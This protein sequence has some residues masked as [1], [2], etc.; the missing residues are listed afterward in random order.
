MASPEFVQRPPETP[1]IQKPTPMAIFL[2]VSVRLKSPEP[3][4]PRGARGVTMDFGILGVFCRRYAVRHTGG[5]RDGLRSVADCAPE[6][7]RRAPGHHTAPEDGFRLTPGGSP[8]PRGAGALWR[9]PAHFRC[10]GRRV[11]PSGAFLRCSSGC[12]HSRDFRSALSVRR[13][14]NGLDLRVLEHVFP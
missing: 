12:R 14:E 2:F 5:G 13:A 1:R 8:H 7:R 9:A 6:H 4:N 11:M 3:Q 10:P